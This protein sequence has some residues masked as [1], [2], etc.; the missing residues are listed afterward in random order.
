V[1]AI[2]PGPSTVLYYGNSQGGIFGTTLMEY[3]PDV[4]RGVLGVPGGIYSLMLPRSVDWPVYEL[5]FGSSYPDLADQRLLLTMFQSAFDIT[6][7]AAAAPYLAANPDRLGIGPKRLL[8][9]AAL[10]DSQVP[11]L[12]TENM[13]RTI[14][15]VPLLRG[16]RRQTWGLEETVDDVPSALVIY[17]VEGAELPPDTN[18]FDGL[19][20]NGVHGFV[21]DHPIPVEQI[22]RFLTGD[23]V[24]HDFCDPDEGCLLRPE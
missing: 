17:E 15:G 19:E 6:D 13:V 18:D 9:H 5:L 23:G 3:H 21:R 11:N 24:I 16:S 8:F 22:A 20:D 12:A 1:A 7:P 2:R 4:A 14:G 10:G